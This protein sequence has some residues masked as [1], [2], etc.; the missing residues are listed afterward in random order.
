MGSMCIPSLGSMCIPSVADGNWSWSSDSLDDW[1]MRDDMALNRGDDWCHD[2]VVM[3][4]A[5]GLM[6][7][8]GR[9][10]LDIVTGDGGFDHTGHNRFGGDN[11]LSNQGL[12]GNE[13]SRVHERSRMEQRS[14][15]Q[16]WGRVEQ[17]GRL[18]QSTG[19]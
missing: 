10:V 18:Q 4:D 13:W 7:Y 19:M 14:R 9:N 12:V 6:R 8:G 2:F 5:L 11:L 15:V 16:E 3:D 17:W 1:S